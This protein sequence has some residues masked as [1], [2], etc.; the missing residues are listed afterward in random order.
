MEM[1]DK[2]TKKY[3]KALKGGEAWN[4]RDS[5]KLIRQD[6]DSSSCVLSRCKSQQSAQ[7]QDT[8]RRD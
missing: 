1:Y 4:L 3:N 7:L 8:H 5:P 2:V 6:L